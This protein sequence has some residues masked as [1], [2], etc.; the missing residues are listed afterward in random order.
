MRDTLN[1]AASRAVLTW[2]YDH[3]G[4]ELARLPK[5]APL[6]VTLSRNSRQAGQPLV[7]PQ[8]TFSGIAR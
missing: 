4:S 3:Y 6:W 2:L 5:D 1:L 7:H 8:D